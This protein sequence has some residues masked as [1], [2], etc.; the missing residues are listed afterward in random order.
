MPRNKF[1]RAQ[2]IVRDFCKSKGI[3]YHETS[4]FGGIR[5]IF[6]HLHQISL[7]ARTVS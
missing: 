1:G 4:V 3:S 7:Y 5:E 6:S 2:K